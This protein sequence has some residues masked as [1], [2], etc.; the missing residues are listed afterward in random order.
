MSGYDDRKLI[1]PWEEDRNKMP[2]PYK[3]LLTLIGVAVLAGVLFNQCSSP[4]EADGLW[5]GQAERRAVT[6]LES[7]A[8]SLRKIERKMK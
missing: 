3:M 6:A 7:I 2:G 8:D 5:A 4:A 1:L